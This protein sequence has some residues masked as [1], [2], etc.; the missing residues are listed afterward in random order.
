LELMDAFYRVMSR[1]AP[2]DEA[3]RQAQLA[4]KAKAEFADPYYW[5]AFQLVGLEH[6]P[7]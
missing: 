1:G 5:A 2:L 7:L 3:L 6:N 4:V